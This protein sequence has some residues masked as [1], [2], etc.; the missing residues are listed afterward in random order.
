MVL[1]HAEVGG[2]LALPITQAPAATQ[3]RLRG[4][5]VFR[6]VAFVTAV[7]AAALPGG[8]RS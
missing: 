4:L 1:L 2:E 5:H 8:G 3:A 6:G 7:T